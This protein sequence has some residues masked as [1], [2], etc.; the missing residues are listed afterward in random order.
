MAARRRHIAAAAD[1][2]VMGDHSPTLGVGSLGEGAAM[3]QPRMPNQYV[4][5]ITQELL[6]SAAVPGDF[7]FKKRRQQT[8]GIPWP[9]WIGIIF[10]AEQGQDIGLA[11]EWPPM[12]SRYKLKRTAIRLDLVECDPDRRIVAVDLW[13]VQIIVLMPISF[14]TDPA[15]KIEVQRHRF[16][17][18]MLQHVG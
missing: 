17:E 18:Q 7:G 9:A 11:D 1:S 16:A 12:R 15:G 3:Q 13:R 5:L 8:L 4:A 14:G 10:S 2:A 6:D